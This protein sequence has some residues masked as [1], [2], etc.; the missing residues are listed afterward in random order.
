MESSSSSIPYQIV[1]AFTD[2][3]LFSGN[4]A[5]VC[6]LDSWPSDVVLQS[7][8][9]QNNLAETSFLSL[10]GESTWK[11]RWFTPTREVTLCGHATLAAG[12]VLIDEGLV[13]RVCHF[14]T[15]SGRLSV[16]RDEGD[17]L[18]MDFPEKPVTQIPF[19]AEMKAL[20]PEMIFLG[21]NDLAYRVVE[22]PTAEDVRAYRPDDRQLREM[23]NI[24]GCVLTAK[25]DAEAEEDFVS[26]F[27]APNAGVPEDPVT[28]SAHCS[29]FSFWAERLEKTHMIARQL[30]ARGGRVMGKI[31]KRGRVQ[32]GGEARTFAEGTLRIR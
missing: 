9:A 23:E 21:K 15:L 10:M 25:G 18:W 16:E 1:N 11:L 7:I 5:A 14:E 3:N 31:E 24:F 19:T 22:V 32:L 27:F 13:E 2:G 30:S 29:L 17:Q 20:F 4:P 28:G 6:L 12:R 8:A 26:R